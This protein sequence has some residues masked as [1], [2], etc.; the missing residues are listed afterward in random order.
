MDTT[1]TGRPWRT[2]SAGADDL[3]FV[4]D[5]ERNHT[6]S[7]A[8]LERTSVA[9]I[10]GHRA[11]YGMWALI[12]GPGVALLDL[13]ALGVHRENPARHLYESAGSS[14]AGEDGDY[15]LFR[16]GLVD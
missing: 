9:E 2:R 6:L 15:L 13:L 8:H 3:P 1:F 7:A 14:P 11:G 10:D 16:R 4:H 5:A 12:D